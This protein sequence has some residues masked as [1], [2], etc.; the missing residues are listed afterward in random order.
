MTPFPRFVSF[1]AVALGCFDIVRGVVHTVLAG[2]V[3]VVTAGLDMAGPTGRDQLTLMAAFGYSN[4]VTGVAL[5]YL[6]LSNRRGAV[7]ML[8]VVPIALISAGV[9]IEY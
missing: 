1:V 9:S 3:G 6:G 7:I 2:N 8:A 4:F 5:I